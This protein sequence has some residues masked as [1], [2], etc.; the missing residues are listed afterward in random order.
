MGIQNTTQVTPPSIFDEPKAQETPAAPAPAPAPSE[1]PK[2]EPK[3]KQEPEAGPGDAPKHGNEPEK[4]P[5]GEKPPERVVPEKYELKLGEGSYLHPEALKRLETY[6]K[7]E[8]LTQEEAMDL[9]KIQEADVSAAIA[10]RKQ[11]LLTEA[12]SDKEIGG[13]HLKENVMLAKRFLDKHGSEELRKEFDR[14]GHGNHKEM[15]RLFSKLERQFGNDKAEMPRNHGGGGGD[16]PFHETFYGP[17]K[18]N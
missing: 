5:D 1:T 2:E 9:V 8:K 12:M 4:K 11:Q 14:Y 13:E 7:S 3:P 17:E 16:K 15:I 6:A 18:T 10:D